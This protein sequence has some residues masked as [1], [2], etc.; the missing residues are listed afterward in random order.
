MAFKE[1]KN[2]H[3]LQCITRLSTLRLYNHLSLVPT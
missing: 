3:D 1:Q 2:S